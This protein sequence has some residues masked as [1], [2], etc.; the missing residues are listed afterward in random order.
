MI[1]RTAPGV[2][3]NRLAG[4]FGQSQNEAVQSPGGDA[5]TILR[6]L[7]NLR[8]VLAFVAALVFVAPA[9]A[10]SFSDISGKW[11]GET[12]DYTFSRSQLTVTFHNGS[13]TK[14]FKVES[15]DMLDDTI[16]MHWVDGSGEKVF[17]DF[18][19]FSRDRTYMAQ[20]KN[21]V[22]PRRPFRRCK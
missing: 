13:P 11:C 16:K 15:Y 22:G 19:E 17:T 12:T 20:Q 21:E 4:S 6:V 14:R 18:S 2:S 1:R 5:M 9:A 10:M 8:V 7:S 3:E